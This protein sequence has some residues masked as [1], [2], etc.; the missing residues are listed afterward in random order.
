ML[1]KFIDLLRVRKLKIITDLKRIIIVGIIIRSLLTPL[2]IGLNDGYYW[3]VLIIDIL[4]GRNPYAF[5]H[6]FYPPVYLYML[7]PFAYF[8][9][10]LSNVINFRPLPI[11]DLS[12]PLY[13]LIITRWGPSMI[14][15]PLSVTLLKIPLIIAD[16]C[17]SLL[18]LNLV[19][20][21]TNDDKRAYLATSMWFLNPLVITISTLWGQIESLVI[22]FTLL[23]IY[24]IYEKRIILSG[25]CAGL[26][27]SCKIFSI[28][29]IFPILFFIIFPH[30]KLNLRKAM[31]F[32]I[33][34]GLTFILISAPFLLFTP[35][36][37]IS[38]VLWPLSYGGSYGIKSIF[39]TLFKFFLISDE[40]IKAFLFC[41]ILITMAICYIFTYKIY[42]LGSC[43]NLL[44]KLV[45]YTFVSF[46]TFAT[47]INERY[48]MFLLP[49]IIIEVACFA[50]SKKVFQAIWL[51]TF[52]YIMTAHGILLFF[53]P[54]FTINNIHREIGDKVL[55]FYDFYDGLILYPNILSPI[56]LILADIP[57]LISLFVLCRYLL[58]AI[59]HIK[60]LNRDKN[61]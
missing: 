53:L 47:G 54:A 6:F 4:T 2:S 52:L 20:K 41:L 58:T 16:T 29:V 45:I 36:D 55:A 51:L 50:M 34:T 5:Q 39:F 49:F 35:N 57:S 27:V 23:S 18:I 43:Y 60:H 8:Y 40:I 28:L 48:I 46:F 59:K 22:L 44:N 38:S 7:A 24:F 19:I 9:S 25:F 15:D 17:V 11:Q 21:I 30:H 32:V 56:L 13:K 61:V 26:A 3:Y 12:F 1:S 37:Y 10:Y 42:C 14:L 31:I 33:T